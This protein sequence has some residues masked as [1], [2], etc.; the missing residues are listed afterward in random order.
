MKFDVYHVVDRVV[1][2]VSMGTGTEANWPA[3]YVKV[4][5]VDAGTMDDVLRLTNTNLEA[6]DGAWANNQG[7]KAERKG[8]RSTSVGDVLVADNGKPFRV[9]MSGYEELTPADK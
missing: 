5:E 2:A 6:E 8:I 1:P 3:D 7:V 9:M 4:A